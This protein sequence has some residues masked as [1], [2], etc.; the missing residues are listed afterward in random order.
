MVNG[1]KRIPFMKTTTADSTK[2]LESKTRSV[3]PLKEDT[4]WTLMLS[5]LPTILKK[6]RQNS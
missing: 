3:L 2:H 6:R 5:A 1:R 4:I